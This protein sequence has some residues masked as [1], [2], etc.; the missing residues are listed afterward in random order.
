MEQLRGSVWPGGWLNGCLPNGLCCDFTP[1]LAPA[2]AWLTEDDLA[3]GALLDLHGRRFRLTRADAYT[4][5]FVAE[6]AQRG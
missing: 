2:Q 6:R 1:S 5:R 3:V 4:E